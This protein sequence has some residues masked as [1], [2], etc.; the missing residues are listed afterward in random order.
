MI[1]R[2]LKEWEPRVLSTNIMGKGYTLISDQNVCWIFDIHLIIQYVQAQPDDGS[3]TLFV[4]AYEKLKMQFIYD[5]WDKK[6]KKAFADIQKRI[7][8]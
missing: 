5:E 2:I 1:W 8:S 6:Q 3:A 4:S 7:G